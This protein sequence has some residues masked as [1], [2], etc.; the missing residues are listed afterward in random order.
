MPK[1]LE[2]VGNLSNSNYNFLLY[3]NSYYLGGDNEFSSTSINVIVKEDNIRDNLGTD[4]INA[5]IHSSRSA[6]YW[7]S[8]QDVKFH[9]PKNLFYQYA[10]PRNADRTVPVG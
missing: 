3:I 10:C 7:H 4:I 6:T 5:Q 8:H 1:A 9:L 2:L